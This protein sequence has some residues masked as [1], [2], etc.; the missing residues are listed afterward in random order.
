MKTSQI[1]DIAIIGAGIAGLT[2]AIYA[3]REGLT[4][5]VLEKAPQEGGRAAT[6]DTHGF[7]FNQ[8]PHALYRA[9]YGRKIL[10]ELDVHYRGG[11]ATYEGSWVLY[12]DEKHLFPGRADV[13][14]NSTFMTEPA[15]QEALAFF[16]QLPQMDCRQYDHV[17]LDLWFDQHIKHAELR[18]FLE[19]L[20]RLSTYCAD[21]DHLSAGAAWEQVIMGGIDGVDYLDDGWKSLVDALQAKAQAFGVEIL[22]RSGVAEI[23]STA[24]RVKIT[25]AD[26]GTC[27]A[28][29]LIATVEPGI[30]ARLVNGGKVTSL[31]QWADSLL[32]V[33]AACLD[34]ALESLPNA[35]NQFVLG[36][37][38][39]LYYSVHTRSAR[40]GPE[41]GAVV[42]L[43]KYLDGRKTVTAAEI[44]DEL[45][46]LMDRLQPGWREILAS[47]R[48]LAKMVVSHAIPS[49][50]MGGTIGRP[51]PQVR[52]LDNVYVAGDWVGGYGMLADTSFT[53]ARDAAALAI[54]KVKNGTFTVN[55]TAC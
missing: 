27:S 11:R 24:E 22:T 10:Q 5:L 7:K 29:T 40:L 46:L 26:G 41:G 12:H 6:Q 28:S 4:V 45:E 32:P 35:E 15:R 44:R 17:P 55:T 19:G 34:V 14:A 3:A 47:K 52:G 20:V 33:H 50:D 25:L 23:E 39:P 43:A 42:Q 16:A 49:A 54:Q 13:M 18:A 2:A 1:Y 51:G 21:F 8:G 36:L 31:Q 30:L 38:E 53:S 9:G 48:F 37:D